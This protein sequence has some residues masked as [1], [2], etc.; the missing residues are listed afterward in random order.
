MVGREFSLKL[1]NFAGKGAG[2]YKI[3]KTGSEKPKKKTD[4]KKKTEEEGKKTVPKKKADAP[5]KTAKK[6]SEGG[7][8]F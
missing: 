8:C 6:A 3:A 7:Y 4:E 2:S 5:K 1:C